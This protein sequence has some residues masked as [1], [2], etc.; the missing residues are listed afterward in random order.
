[1]TPDQHR[2]HN[3]LRILANTDHEDLK[4]LTDGE[5][6]RFQRD[7]F[8]YFISA[9]DAHKDAIWALIES[10][11]PRRDDLLAELQMQNVRLD[12][13]LARRNTTIAD[14]VKALE[15]LLKPFA[16]MPDE[17]LRTYPDTPQP[18]A[19]LAAREAIAAARNDGLAGGGE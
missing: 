3:G 1:M 2:F 14:L 17:V 5:W 18:I 12:G 10:R 13:T 4:T 11:Q 6:I 16:T 15:A 7:P 19:I 9:S 8:R